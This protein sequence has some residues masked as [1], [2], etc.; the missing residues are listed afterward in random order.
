[1]NVLLDNGFTTGKII[2]I[3]ARIGLYD[4][5]LDYGTQCDIDILKNQMADD[6]VHIFEVLHQKP[7]KDDP[8][9]C[10]LIDS[11]I[12][13][14]NIEAV[15]V[16]QDTIINNPD[17][18]LFP[19]SAFDESLKFPLDQR[20]LELSEIGFTPYSME[21]LDS[22]VN[23]RLLSNLP[24]PDNIAEDLLKAGINDLI[25]TEIRANIN[26]FNYF[27][28]GGQITIYYSYFNADR[29]YNYHYELIY[30]LDAEY[31]IINASGLWHNL[32]PEYTPGQNYEKS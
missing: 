7:F 1:M 9:F 16:Y 20:L 15:N 26:H 32:E 8:V 5:L 2:N 13:R 14:N 31:N 4:R 29:S 19:A 12:N 22:I 30:K 24:V 28:D 11:F 10:A 18:T 27:N 21:L 3:F 25:N 6:M 23:N 17:Y